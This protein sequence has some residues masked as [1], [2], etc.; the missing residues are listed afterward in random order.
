[1]A[2][3]RHNIE[4]RLTLNDG[5]SRTVTRIAARF[6]A[7]SR[8]VGR[9]SNSLKR[10]GAGAA[11]LARGLGSV[12]APLGLIASAALGGGIAAHVER[13]RNWADETGKL[14]A[15]LGV[16][17]EFLSELGHAADQSGVSM[18]MLNVGMNT[19]VR[20]LGRARA[21]QGA[22]YSGL[23]KTNPELIRQMNLAESSEEAYQIAVE[24]IRGLGDEAEQ[25]RVA[26]AIF[27]DE[28]AKLLR[29][30]RQTPEEIARLRQEAKWL[31]ISLGQDGAKSAAGFNDAMDKLGKAF[32]GIANG[33]AT[34]VLP[35]FSELAD[36]LTN[37]LAGNREET[38]KA[39]SGAFLDLAKAIKN[40]DW[41]EIIA[42][43]KDAAAGFVTLAKNL[44]WLADSV[45][46]WGN[47][48]IG[49][50][51]AMQAQVIVA[52]AQIAIGLG[53]FAI[54]AVRAIPAILAFTGSAITGFTAA[55]LAAMRGMG[56]AIISVVTMAGTL[57]SFI[58]AMIAGLKAL[59]LA[60]LTNP[61]GLAIAGIVI[62]LAMLWRNWD[63][64]STAVIGRWESVAE[65]FDVSFLSGLVSIWENSFGL[66]GDILDVF[67]KDLFGFSIKGF[68]SAL[69]A[70]LADGVASLLDMIPPIVRPDFV[71]GTIS[72]L[73]NVA[74]SVATP[75]VASP[76][77]VVQPE[78]VNAISQTDLVAAQVAS[79]RLDGM[80]GDGGQ[81]ATAPATVSEGQPG[82]AI[83]APMPLA[84]LVPLPVPMP[85]RIAEAARTERI[86]ESREVTQTNN[87]R[88]QISVDFAN[89][90]TGAT[91]ES[92]FEG[93]G[94]ELEVSRGDIAMGSL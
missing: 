65:A 90:P 56:M 94:A 62:A 35:A 45:G 59:G 32:N 30:I 89:L 44:Q 26:T 52:L 66:M 46:G 92:D 41:A 38:V 85:G 11:T 33:I 43:V 88:A 70:D 74:S 83:V 34:A 15:Q 2:R 72:S 49:V 63:E 6:T 21:A 73:R 37:V 53:G 29:L 68:V 55:G 78:T 81:V 10:M 51:I 79:A 5:L 60:F 9:M 61:I 48:I 54:N 14:A 36:S 24:A 40:A 25:T 23:I 13:F 87:S 82:S 76:P 18:E 12:M 58:P 57:A 84:R 77:E 19:M 86:A 1:M 16:S 20:R 17:T 75:N 93:D 67:L 50:F 64:I 3:V 4:S 22:L 8:A 71:D 42:N 28:Q 69:K 27:G 80:R 47:L 91:V 31:G 39:M 7:M